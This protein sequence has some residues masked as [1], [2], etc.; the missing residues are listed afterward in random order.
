MEGARSTKHD[1]M[2]QHKWTLQERCDVTKVFF[3]HHTPL[4]PWDLEPDF[5]PGYLHFGHIVFTGLISSLNIFYL[6]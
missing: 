2:S 3:G 1:M 6:L 5:R 4:D